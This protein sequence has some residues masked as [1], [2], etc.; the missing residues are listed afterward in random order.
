MQFELRPLLK[1]HAREAALLTQA[2]YKNNPFRQILWP[3]GAPSALVEK[4]TE[5]VEKTLSSPEN[6]AIQIYDT[7]AQKIAS[8][9]LWNY[10][11]PMSDEDWDREA[12]ERPYAFGPLLP[13]SRDLCAPF[14]VQE[15]LAKRRVMGNG[16]R[17]WELDSLAT[18]PEYERKGLGSML[19]RWGIERMEERGWPS[20]IVATEKGNPLYVKHGYQVLR[21]WGVDLGLHGGDGVYRNTILVR[22][23]SGKGV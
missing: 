2:A 1:E 22:Y 16:A 20:V 18:A 5:R 23:P 6:S 13:E 14:L 10:T 11:P 9:A 3:D 8:F 7:D 15:T 17:W 4:V 21:S 12:A 19:V